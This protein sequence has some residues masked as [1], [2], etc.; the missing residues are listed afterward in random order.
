MISRTSARHKQ[1]LYD[2]RH[3]ASVSHG[4]PDYPLA[5]AGTKLCLATEANVCEQLVLGHTQQFS[6]WDWTHDL[7]LQV[8]CPNHSGI[9]PHIHVHKLLK[10]QHSTSSSLVTVFKR[11]R[12]KSSIIVIKMSQTIVHS[13]SRRIYDLNQHENRF[14]STQLV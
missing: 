1:K 2:H 3:G 4:V 9:K 10:L 13:L 8:Q 6:N 12:Q 5:Y 11:V 7:Q 14:S